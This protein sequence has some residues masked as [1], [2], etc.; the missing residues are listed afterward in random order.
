MIP[1]TFLILSQI[2]NPHPSASM[3]PR[4]ST[5]QEHQ[6]DLLARRGALGV[7][8][9]P[10][11]P[12]QAQKLGLQPGQGVIAQTPINGLTAQIAG[13]KAGDIITQ[14][15]SNPVSASMIGA[16][17]R[18]TPA[19]TKITFSIIREGKAVELSSK[20]TERPR[21][22][23]N[24]NYE[25]IYSHIVSN[26]QMMRTIVTKPRKSGKYPGFFFIQGFSPVS[27][28]YVLETST[29][30][31]AT[32]DGPLLKEFANSGFVTIR[33]EKPGV[34]DSQ[35]G[36]FPQLDYT[37]ELD[38]Y[39]KTLIQL[40]ARDDVDQ[41]NIFIFGHSMGGAFGPMIATENP[42][43]GIAVY[44]VAARTWYEYLLDT[45][46]YQ[47]I[48]AGDT[49]ESADETVRQSAK[50]VN[51][52][53]GE[54][55]SPEEFKK[56]FPELAPLTDS[57]IPGGLF[58]GKSLDF[59]RQLAQTN[60]A[61]YWAKCGA[62]TLAVRGETDFVTYDADH[63]LIADIVNKARP[64]TAEFLIAKRSD[65]VF[66]DFGTEA[67]SQ[68]NFTKGRFNLTFTKML[69]AWIAKTIKRP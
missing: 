42:V 27:Y 6:T 55:Q 61:S 58:N 20:L 10:L 16:W 17:V 2:A 68:A 41:N 33:V 36:P 43:K 50:L 46:R 25:V 59:W 52:I 24:K 23:G 28:D 67:E 62:Y 34:G 7:A 51:R 45:I 47:G 31:V 49:Y 32:L 4:A 8:F 29:G 21:D 54:G 30:D 53:F 11:P 15:N 35:G 9:S 26:G 44:G 64:G 39:R 38:I 57:L 13:I 18:E 65:H 3:T 60:F 5:I 48:L 63:K 19:G 66:H 14:L 12:D 22:P 69:K 37:T 56:Q 40:K 1:A